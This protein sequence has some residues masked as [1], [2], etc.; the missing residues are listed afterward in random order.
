[1]PFDRDKIKQAASELAAK[2]VFIG[3]SSWKYEGWLGQLH[4]PERYAEAPRKSSKPSDQDWFPGLQVES[5]PPMPPKFD[6]D[7][8]KRD[9][10]CEYAEVFKTVSV[11]AGY[12][13][14]PAVEYLQGLASHVPDDFRFGF[15]VTDSITFKKYPYGERHGAKA[16]QANADFLNADLF[17]TAFLKPCAEIRPKIGLLMFEFSTFRPGDYQHV[18]E[19]IAHLDA[20]LDKLPQGWPYGIELRN[21]DWLTSEYFGCLA[22]HGVTHVFN[23]WEAMPTV[24]EQMALPDS[25]TNPR[26]VAA[27]FLLKPGR[28]YEHAVNLFEPYERVKEPNADARAAGKALIA[29]GRNAGPDRKSFYYMNNRLEGNALETITAMLEP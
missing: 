23:N 10:L 19:F 12:Y 13:K 14:F 29:E 8:F 4:T 2:G 7:A 5:P 28:K 15:K 27:R 17:A 24:G 1:M 20:F 11:D 18:G 22:Q 16:G 9:C 25:R 21:K 26:R 3:T 6:K